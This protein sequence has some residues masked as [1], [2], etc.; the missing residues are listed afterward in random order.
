MFYFEHP[1]CSIDVALSGVYSFKLSRI[2]TV[3]RLY[4][5]AKDI[6]VNELACRTA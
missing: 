1:R 5:S 3:K 2:M 4:L 6:I